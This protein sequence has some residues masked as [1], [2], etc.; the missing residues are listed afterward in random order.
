MSRLGR[1]QKASVDRGDETEVGQ[2]NFTA[3][4]SDQVK[5]SAHPPPPPAPATKQLRSPRT[6]TDLEQEGLRAWIAD[7]PRAPRTG[8]G[9]QGN[10]ARL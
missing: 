1:R 3:D 7:A 4:L 8:K 6:G 10:T 9:S 5:G 2:G